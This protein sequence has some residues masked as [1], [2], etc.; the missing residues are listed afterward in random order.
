MKN[1]SI[2][3]K[4]TELI[5]VLRGHFKGKLNLARGNYLQR[6]YAKYRQLIILG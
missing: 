1:S 4:N 2:D 5:S 6:L 3:C